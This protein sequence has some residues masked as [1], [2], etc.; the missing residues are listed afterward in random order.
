MGRP[1]GAADAKTLEVEA[2][3]EARALV[4]RLQGVLPQMARVLSVVEYQIAQATGI[5]DRRKG[6]S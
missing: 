2:L 1:R 5:A 3:M 4:K 6:R